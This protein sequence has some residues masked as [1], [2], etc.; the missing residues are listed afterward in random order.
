MGPFDGLKRRTRED[1]PLCGIVTI[2]ES[3]GCVSPKRIVRRRFFRHTYRSIRHFVIEDCLRW[4][5]RPPIEHTDMRWPIR[6]QL[7]V[8]TILIAI[9]AI[10]LACAA[11]AYLAV[12]AAGRSKAQELVRIE[13]TLSQASFPLT[14][15]VLGQMSGLSGAEFVLL[16]DERRVLHATIAL[17]DRDMAVLRGASVTGDLHTLAEAAEIELGGRLY[18]GHVVS[19]NR[20]SPALPGQ[21]LMV[22]YGKDQW[23]AVARRVA[24][25]IMGAGLV[26]ILLAACLASLMAGWIVR[27]IQILKAQAERIAGGRFEP[28]AMASRNDE[29]ADLTVSLNRMTERLSQFEDE[30]RRSEQL[31]TLDQLAAGMAHTLRN[32]ATGARLAI[33]IH[34]RKHPEAVASESLETALHQ[35]ELLESHVWRFLHLGRGGTT[36]AATVDMN[37]VVEGALQLVRPAFAH[38]RIRLESSYP[39]DAVYVEGEL[40]SLR[41]LTLNLLLNA[42]EATGKAAG[43]DPSVVL[44]FGPSADDSATL[45]VSDSGPGPSD[46]LR[47]RLF[48]PFVS[49]K[50]DGT[51]L[52]LYLSR[53]I[54]EAHGGSIRW[55]RVDGMTVFTVQLPRSA[56]IEPK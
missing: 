51:G 53:R 47:D 21:L 48:E 25:P 22:L 24:S 6:L 39:S 44:E 45:R 50:P 4:S 55:E 26:A 37:R 8:A 52:G 42:L 23:W 36:S 5:V 3:D 31:R 28:V 17:G 10:A 18:F 2:V 49:E 30:V 16:D 41:E 11:S 20:N 9:T 35:L 19:P 27:P 1:C 14:E 56:H 15:N 40:E 43:G 34:Q 54:A 29:L 33:E 38:A 12:S 7:L 32:A 46:R 13:K